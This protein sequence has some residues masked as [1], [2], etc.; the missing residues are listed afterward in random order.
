MALE[1]AVIGVNQNDYKMK[2]DLLIKDYLGDGSILYSR[3]DTSLDMYRVVIA[4]LMNTDHPYSW[5]QHTIWS[6]AVPVT[7]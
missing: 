5:L 6:A 1:V 7:A 4:D 3:L 2:L